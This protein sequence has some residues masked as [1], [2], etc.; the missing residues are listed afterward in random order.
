M[1]RCEECQVRE[2]RAE[3]DGKIGYAQCDACAPKRV[4]ASELSVADRLFLKDCLACT[5]R[6]MGTARI[7]TGRRDGDW[8]TFVVQLPVHSWGVLPSDVQRRI[9]AEADEERSGEG[10]TS[11]LGASF[12]DIK[13]SGEVVS[14]VNTER[15][16]ET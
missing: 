2:G 4:E 8:V 12:Q 14:G 3:R 16:G 9:D 11:R 1:T 13:R 5:S 15:E 7:T 6:E 10:E